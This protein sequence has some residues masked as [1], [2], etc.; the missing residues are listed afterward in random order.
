M[1][2]GDY[3]P[4]S[5]IRQGQQH[6]Q[7]LAHSYSTVPSGQSAGIAPAAKNTDTHPVPS[8]S[9]WLSAETLDMNCTVDDQRRHCFRLLKKKAGSPRSVCRA[10]SDSCIRQYRPSST[11][12]L[13]LQR[14]YTVNSP[15][16]AQQLYAE[17]T[18]QS[19]FSAKRIHGQNGE[20]R[21]GTR[22]SSAS[23][24]LQ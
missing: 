17:Q 3:L 2:Q 20:N 23:R 4:D 15:S 18:S 16:L 21:S 9:T 5:K 19:S 6:R 12:R 10:Q 14:Q 22:R 8:C 13:C 7:E 1:A 11:A 24:A